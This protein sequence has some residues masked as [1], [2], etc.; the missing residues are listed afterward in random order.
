[1]KPSRKSKTKRPARHGLFAELAEGMAALAEAREGKRTLR[2]HP[3]LFKPPPKL[4]PDDVIRVRTRLRLS[5]ALF[6]NFLRTNSRT[7]ENWEQGRARPNAQAA[8]LISLV[9]KFPDMVER[10]AKV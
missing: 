6:A 8:L 3:V 2:T 5:R 9:N 7:L 10:L 4:K 1:M